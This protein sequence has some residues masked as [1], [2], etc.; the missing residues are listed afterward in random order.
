MQDEKPV[1]PEDREFEQAL[2]SIRP[3]RPA[4]TRDQVL[5]ETYRRAARRQA[6]L[7]RGIAAALAAGLAL[8]LL[9][10]PAPRRIERVVY[11]P[12]PATVIQPLAAGDGGM[13]AADMPRVSGGYLTLRQDVL[14]YGLA[15]LTRSAPAAPPAWAGD[16]L[17]PPPRPMS[18]FDLLN[19]LNIRGRS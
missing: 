17:P 19:I 11:Q 15:A 12:P 4:L 18:V 10:R 14:A 3:V 8:S 1:N 16:V 5:M 7:W 9:V 6:W 2:A 13:A